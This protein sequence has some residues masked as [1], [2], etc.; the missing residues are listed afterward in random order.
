[1]KKIQ[2]LLLTLTL[3]LSLL[4]M[5]STSQAATA[6]SLKPLKIMVSAVRFG[7]HKLAL[8]Y[9]ADE[10]QGKILVGKD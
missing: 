8:N 4:S 9:L 5:P 6:P 7:K 10:A 3:S 1:M 2:L